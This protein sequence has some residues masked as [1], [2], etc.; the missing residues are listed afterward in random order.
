[1]AGS[2][3]DSGDS[4]EEDLRAAYETEPRNK[5]KKR[6]IDEAPLPPPPAPSHEEH[7]PAPTT[8]WLLALAYA[9][10]IVGKRMREILARNAERMPATELCKNISASV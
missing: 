5:D 7:P 10:D 2:H 4:S 8:G 9:R 1:M 3:D 6:K